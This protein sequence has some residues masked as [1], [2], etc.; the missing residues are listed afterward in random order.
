LGLHENEQF[1]SI[2]HSV[3]VDSVVTPGRVMTVEVTAH[4]DVDLVWS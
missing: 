3:A 2:S 1:L 4:D